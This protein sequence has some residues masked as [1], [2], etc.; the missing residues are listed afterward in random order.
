MLKKTKMRGEQVTRCERLPAFRAW[1]LAALMLI[2]GSCLQ[3]HALTI[4]LTYDSSVPLAYENAVHYAARQLENLISDNITVNIRVVAVPGTSIFGQSNYPLVPSSYDEIRGALVSHATSMNDSTAVANLP[5]TDP[6]GGGSFFVSTALAK[7]LGIIGPSTISDGTF[8][9]GSGNNFTL[10]PSNRAVTGK[11]DFIGLAEHE[12]T[13]IM[14]RGAGLGVDFGDGK[15]G[16]IPFDLFRFSAPGVRSLV[17]GN[18]NYF[19]IDNGATNLNNYNFPNGNGSDPQDWASG[20]ND[21]C[22]SSVFSGVE[23]DFSAVDATAMDV[24]GYTLA[25][26]P[27]FTNGPPPGNAT[28]NAAYN[29]TYTV[30]A[31]PSATFAVVTGSNLPPGLNLS[32][33]GILSGTPIQTGTFSGS[34]SATNS[35][36]TVTQNFSITVS[37]ASPPISFTE[38]ES[39]HSMPLGDPTISGP[40]ATPE[41]DGIPNLLKYFYNID[42]SRPMN[43]ADRNALPAVSVTTIGSTTYLTLTYRQYAQTEIVPTVQTSLDLKTWGAAT[44]PIFTQLR[45]DSN[46]HD[47]IIQ[48]QVAFT[49]AKQFIRL[50]ITSH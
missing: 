41:N 36:G 24:M 16:Y 20:N 30:T 40:S 29:F 45:L 27:T 5:M 48:V 18:N 28:V 7:A 17:A 14:G 47:P 50:N 39:L 13:E 11:Y 34:V 33:S 15:P 4:N 21:A 10:D 42:P 23:N 43:A 26:A 31:I 3:V 32:S 49:G 6:T 22:N 8:T 12:I 9:F 46:T 1:S 25:V 44:N 38:W 37:P 2:P 35:A 19:S